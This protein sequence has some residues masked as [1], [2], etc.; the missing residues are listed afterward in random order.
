MSYQAAGGSGPL[1]F[2]GLPFLVAAILDVCTAQIA[3]PLAWRSLGFNPTWGQS[4]AP[5]ESPQ[6][7][8]VSSDRFSPSRADKRQQTSMDQ[9]PMIRYY[10]PRDATRL[11]DDGEPEMVGVYMHAS[12]SSTRVEQGD[13]GTVATM[14][15]YYSSCGTEPVLAEIYA[16]RLYT[17]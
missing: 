17:L 13:C 8:D 5:L 3:V 4:G 1:A 11:G 10:A 12:S 2:V 16:Q 7:V 9:R 14:V 6:Q 15:T